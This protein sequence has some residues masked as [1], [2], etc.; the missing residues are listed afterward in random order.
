MIS[1]FHNV[2]LLQHQFQICYVRFI[3][4]EYTFLV[5]FWCWYSIAYVALVYGVSIWLIEHPLSICRSQNFR[6]IRLFTVLSPSY[7]RNASTVNLWRYFTIDMCVLRCFS[8]RSPRQLHSSHAPTKW[9]FIGTLLRT[10]FADRKY[11]FTD[12]FRAILNKW[13]GLKY[14]GESCKALVWK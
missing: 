11:C 3:I 4:S 5:L 9:H 10:S 8:R 1:S 7:R 2:F 12:L 14:V 6:A 13:V